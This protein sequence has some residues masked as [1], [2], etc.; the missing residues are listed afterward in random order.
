MGLFDWLFGRGGGD[1]G[2]RTSD[3]GVYFQ[4]RCDAC[5]EVIRGRLN[6]GSE[7]SPQDNG[8]YY[9]RKVLIGQQCFRPIETEFRFADSGGRTALA[10]DARGGTFVDESGGDGA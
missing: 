7:I 6:P 2:G 5:G 10:R 8:T 1:G 3:G 4:V 9:V